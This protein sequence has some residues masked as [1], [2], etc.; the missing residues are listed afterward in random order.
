MR[1]LEEIPAFFFL[2][3]V[4]V[5]PQN[6]WWSKQRKGLRKSGFE[7]GMQEYTCE[8]AVKSDFSMDKA[9]NLGVES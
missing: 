8:Q 3:T 5:P 9:S 4:E 1:R 7:K 6:L 2:K